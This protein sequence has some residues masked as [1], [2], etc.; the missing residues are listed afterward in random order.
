MHGAEYCQLIR[1]CHL[2]STREQNP[3][4]EMPSWEPCDEMKQTK[5]ANNGDGAGDTR[6]LGTSSSF[7]TSVL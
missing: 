2:R 7:E 5:D 4:T 3:E 6:S 1:S